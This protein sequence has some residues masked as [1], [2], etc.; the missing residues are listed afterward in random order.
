MNVKKKRQIKGKGSGQLT[1][2]SGV[3]SASRT[4]I[5]D[6]NDDEWIRWRDDGGA[7]TGAPELRVTSID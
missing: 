3:G 2:K 6:G 1:G 7:G 4:S 5:F